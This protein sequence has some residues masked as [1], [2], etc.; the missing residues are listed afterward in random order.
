MMSEPSSSAAI[1]FEALLALAAE[2][3]ASDLHLKDG[4]PP[5]LRISGQVHY[6]DRP[7]MTSGE[8]AALADTVMDDRLR[9]HLAERGDA[10][11][12]CAIGTGDRFRI[13]VYR[14]RGRT[15]LAAR[16]V[17]RDIPSFGDLHMPRESMERICKAR[18]GLVLFSGVAGSGKS[19]SI[20]AC[21]DAVN[22]E[23][24]CHIV[25]IEDPIEYL[26]EDKKAFIHQREIGTDVVSFE[27][28]LP[29]LLREDPDVVLVGEMRTAESLEGALRAAVT[30]RLV[31]TTLHAMRAPAA[32]AR[33]LDLAG[34]RDQQ[35]VREGVANTLVAVVCQQLVPAIDP[36]VA[37]VPATEVMFATASIRK[38]IREGEDERLSALISAGGE[39]GMHDMTQDL[40]R[41]VQEE[42]VEPKAAYEAAP[43]A[44]ALKMIIRGIG[45]QKGTLR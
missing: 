13:N 35:R 42:W 11:L 7:A 37:R 20:A 16:R 26:F 41:L 12:S 33:I 1:A 32:I 9:A 31:F 39:A 40:A 17:S 29:A 45:F 15:G 44:E 10:D 22:A 5:I 34:P 38:A 30:S 28:A 25:T 23:R 27:A 14:E 6:M 36:N 24:A 4:R 2:R 8:I 43:N 21:I 19:T 3:G 18:Q